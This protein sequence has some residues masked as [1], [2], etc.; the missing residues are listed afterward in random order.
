MRPWMGCL[1]SLLLSLVC[2]CPT[3]TVLWLGMRGDVV[4]RT[5]PLGELRLWMARDERGPVLAVSSVRA[6][7]SSAGADCRATRVQFLRIWTYP[8]PESAHYCTCATADGGSNE[9]PGACPP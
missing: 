3:W 1:V 6:V 8:G 7:P 2:L 4:V 5:A 9:I